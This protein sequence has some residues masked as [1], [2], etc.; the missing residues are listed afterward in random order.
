MPDS[1]TAT[2]RRRRSR[3]SG[4]SGEK[5]LTPSD[6]IVSI[7]PLPMDA[8]RAKDETVRARRLGK[9]LPFGHPY[10]RLPLWVPYW[11]ARLINNSAPSSK[12]PRPD[13]DAG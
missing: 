1:I 12:P 5:A 4:N 7:Y 2:R 9:K 3:S 6:P 10:R 13:K 8:K 11:L